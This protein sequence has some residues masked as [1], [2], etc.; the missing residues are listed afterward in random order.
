MQ[1]NSTLIPNSS[2]TT[3]TINVNM[4]TY[5]PIKMCIILIEETCSIA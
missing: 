1:H 5:T 2:V 4:L 3:L